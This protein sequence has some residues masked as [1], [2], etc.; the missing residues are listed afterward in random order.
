MREYHSTAQV[1]LFPYPFPGSRPVE[2]LWKSRG[3]QPVSTGIR[4][5]PPV[6]R[7]SNPAAISGL[8]T[9]SPRVLTARSLQGYRLTRLLVPT[10]ELVGLF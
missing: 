2:G 3:H 1:P 5:Y 4:Q 6:R 10:R 8:S 7:C 9:A